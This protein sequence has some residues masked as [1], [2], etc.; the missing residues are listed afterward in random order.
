MIYSRT[1]LIRHE[2][3]QAPSLHFDSKDNKSLSTSFVGL[4]WFID[5]N[6]GIEVIQH[7]GGIDGYSS[8]AGF[9]LTKQEGV[10]I[11][12]SCETK[13]MPPVIESLIKLKLDTL[14]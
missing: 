6:L 11:L 8:F 5:T 1:H 3:P 9:N 14:F 2:Y 13:D 4:G 7:S 12:C 10:A